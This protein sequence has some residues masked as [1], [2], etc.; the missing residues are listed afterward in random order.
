MVIAGGDIAL[1]SL[2]MDDASRKRFDELLAGVGQAGDPERAELEMYVDEHP[3]LRL[4]LERRLRELE[5][6]EGW[7]VR[8]EADR[9]LRTRGGSARVKLERSV[10]LG[11]LGGGLVLSPLV[12]PMGAVATV[13]GT[14]VLIWSFVRMRLQEAKDDPYRRI[15]Q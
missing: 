1:P 12:G 15:D 4:E 10:G 3:E 7:L 9:A 14:A 8:A 11:L 13:A 6:G 5:L 2:R